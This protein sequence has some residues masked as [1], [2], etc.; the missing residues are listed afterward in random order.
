MPTLPSRGSKSSSV[1]RLSRV[2]MGGSERILLYAVSSGTGPPLFPLLPSPHSRLL[3]VI[4][5]SLRGVDLTI[6]ENLAAFLDQAL[7]VWSPKPSHNEVEP[8]GTGKEKEWD[9]RDQLQK[10]TLQLQAKEKEVR[11]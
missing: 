4:G 1:S 10:K 2:P 5:P 8:E 6:T 9:F 3:S 7:P 11:R